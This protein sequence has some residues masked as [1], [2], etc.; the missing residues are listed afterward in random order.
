MG[1]AGGVG[2]AGEAG[3]SATISKERMIRQLFD[4]NLKSTIS[5]HIHYFNLK[6]I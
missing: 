1:E 4:F 2:G 3:G 5:F 6:G